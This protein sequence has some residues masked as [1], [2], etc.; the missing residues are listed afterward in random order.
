MKKSI[1][2]SVFVAA[3]FVIFTPTGTSAQVVRT[4]VASTGN[5]A[6]PCSRI[7]PCRTFQTALNA[8]ASEGEVVALDSAGFGSNVTITKPISIIASP[9]VYAGI[10][11]FSGDGIIIDEG[12]ADHTFTTVVLR[13]LTL[14]N[15]GSS[16]NGILFKAGGTLVIEDCVVNGFSSANVAGIAFKGPGM[17]DVK[18]S[19]IRGNAAGVL[20]TPSSGSAQIGIDHVRL[21][22]NVNGIEAHEGSTV[23]IRNSVASSNTIFGFYCVSRTSAAAELNIESC[24]ASN[25]AVAGIVTESDSTGVATV[26]LSNCTVTDNEIGLDNPG[27]IAVLL[28][29]GNNTVEGNN[30]NT[31]GAIGFYTAK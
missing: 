21:E 1:I 15:Q 9:G 4:F 7:A 14:I 30:T 22:R 24:L 11:V 28:S 26:R 25:N 13:G 23:T 2:A 16:D 5:D 18:D 6:N 3:V 12:N 27:P 8:A 29:R 31:L 10:T 17:L 19:I 20:V